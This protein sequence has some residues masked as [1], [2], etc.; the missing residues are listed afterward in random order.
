MAAI[1]KVSSNVTAW[2]ATTA[3]TKNLQKEATKVIPRW[4]TGRYDVI[5]TSRYAIDGKGKVS[6]E[7]LLSTSWL[8]QEIQEKYNDCGLVYLHNTGLKDMGDQRA[9]ARIIMGNETEY[10]GGANPRDRAGELANVYDIGAPLIAD[11]AY[12]HEMTYKRHSCK[13]LGFLCK[14]AVTERPG[15]GWSYVS[16]SVQAHDYLMETDVGKKLKEK[17][18]CFIRRMTDATAFHENQQGNAPGSVYNHWQQSWMTNDPDEAEERAK[19]QGLHVEWIEDE[20]GGGRVMQTRYYQSAFAYLPFLDRNILV[21]S[22]AD[23]GEWFDTWPGIMDV[24]QEKRP[25]EMLFGDDEP[26]TLE[27]KQTWTD[28]YDQFGIPIPWQPGDVAVLCNMR[29]AHGRPGVHLLPGEQRVLGVM[30]GPMYKLEETRE[31]KW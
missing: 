7:D 24:P 23:D 8:G 14:H 9:L 10:E 1:Q 2:A 13:N 18:L 4:W 31:N 19:T 27:E 15:V 20:E 11:L 30:L 28:A 6:K 17:G 22:I 29:F 3:V 25:L 16:D 5:A 12:H 26:F 21:T